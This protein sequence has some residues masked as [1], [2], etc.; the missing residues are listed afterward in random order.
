M[1]MT[2][3]I[4]HFRPSKI[5]C[6]EDSPVFIIGRSGAKRIFLGKFTDNCEAPKRLSSGS[7]PSGKPGAA[8]W[9]KTKS[10]WD[11]ESFIFPRAREWVSEW[12]EWTSEWTS[13]RPC[14][15]T[16]TLGCFVRLC[17]GSTWEWIFPP[18]KPGTRFTWEWK[19]PLGKPGA[20]LIWG[21]RV[22][23]MRKIDAWEN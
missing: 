23:K 18:R 6:W 17:A 12:C 19:L 2:R 20:G 9:D 5:R 3:V 7:F 11:I 22:E 10:F 21:L 4:K 1:E 16:P 8:L 15:Y 14:T 13:K